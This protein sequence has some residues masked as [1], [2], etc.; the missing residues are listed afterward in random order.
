MRIYIYLKKIFA[1]FDQ[2]DAPKG[3]VPSFKSNIWQ[4]YSL[5]AI[6]CGWFGI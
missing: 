6:I 4:K 1:L 2:Q 3:L 5:V